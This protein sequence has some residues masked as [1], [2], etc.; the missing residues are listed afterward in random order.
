MLGLTLQRGLLICFT[1]I[2]IGLPFWLH[3][4]AL[5]V[6]CGTVTPVS[7]LPATTPAFALLVVG[8]CAL[9]PRRAYFAAGQNPQ[10]AA[11]A[12]RYMIMLL[13]ALAFQSVFQCLSR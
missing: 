8:V 12:A 6:L 5:L 10:I 4:E 2:I 9:S 11:G 1:F 7:Y 13:P 3:I